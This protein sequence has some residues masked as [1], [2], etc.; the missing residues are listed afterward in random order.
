M[1]AGTGGCE[2]LVNLE[3]PVLGLTLTQFGATLKS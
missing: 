1:G 2:E 3:R